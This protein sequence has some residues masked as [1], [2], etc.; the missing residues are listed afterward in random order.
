[1]LVANKANKGEN[2]E[3]SALT[4]HSSLGNPA[5]ARRDPIRREHI[6]DR[7]DDRR[8]SNS[9]SWCGVHVWASGFELIAN[10]DYLQ[11][12]VKLHARHIE[13]CLRTTVVALSVDNN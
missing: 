5:E 6:A 8:K 2:R 7:S 11:D 10:N 12:N 3:S 4:K 1:M 9:K 13:R